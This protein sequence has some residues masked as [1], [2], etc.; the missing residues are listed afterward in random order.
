MT[1][2]ANAGPFGYTQF[3]ATVTVRNANPVLAFTH[4]HGPSIFGL[5][6][7]TAELVSVVP[8]P[9]AVLAGMGG[10]ASVG[11]VG[12]IRRRRVAK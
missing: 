5:D 6:G 4:R 8:L 7:I 9:P 10:L 12:A 3:T 11:I 2:I 1:P